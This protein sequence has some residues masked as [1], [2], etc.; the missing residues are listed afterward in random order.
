MCL[1]FVLN[2]N[3]TWPCPKKMAA[4]LPYWE[5]ERDMWLLY[6]YFNTFAATH[7]KKTNTSMPSMFQGLMNIGSIWVQHRVSPEPFNLLLW[8][9]HRMLLI[10]KIFIWTN[11][12]K[13]NSHV[14]IGG[15]FGSHIDIWKMTKNIYFMQKKIKHLST[16]YQTWYLF[17][18]Y[19]V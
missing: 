12:N 18:Y 3:P 6:M 7:L 19:I 11:I 4:K 9:F 15:H 14:T 13:Q 5:R 10:Y 2:L 16:K 17:R 1:V 8:N